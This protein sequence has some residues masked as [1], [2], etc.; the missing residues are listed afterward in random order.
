[1]KPEN[2]KLTL[3]LM[4]SL[5]LGL[6]FTVSPVGA[7]THPLSQITPIDTDLD[8]DG[9][10]ITNVYAIS[11]FFDDPCPDGEVLMHITDT[12]N[13][14]C[15]DPTEDIRDEFVGVAGDTMTGDLIMD[16]ATVTGLVSPVDDTDAVRLTDLEDVEN[17][18]LQ[19][20][21]DVLSIGEDAGGLNM[22]NIGQVGIGTAEPGYE[23]DVVGDVGFSGTLQE[24][25]VPWTRLTDHVDV[26]GGTGITGGGALSSS[27]ELAFDTAWGDDRYYEQSVADGEFVGVAGDTMTGDL[28]MEGAT[29]TGLVSPVDDTDAVRLTDLEDVENDILQD[30]EDVLS[31]GNF[32]GGMGIDMNGGT[33]YDIGD[34]TGA[35]IVDSDQIESNAVSLSELDTTDVDDRYVNQWERWESDLE[36]DGDIQINDGGATG[37]NVVSGRKELYAGDETNVSSGATKELTLVFNE[38]YGH[39]PNHVNVL[40]RVDGEITVTI[41]E[42]SKTMIESGEI[43]TETWDTSEWEDGTY[44]VTATVDSGW[45][46]II[47]FY[48]VM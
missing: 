11:N 9:R 46:D 30:L 29:V 18:T 2:R 17:D 37:T 34:L 16:G 24:G 6:I 19:D 41:N 48:Y 4:T 40:A 20:L 44:D 25:S 21:E 26:T 45:N 8:M 43:I 47:E 32:T 27:R 7:Q 38:N 5:V 36:V 15:V 1:M 28:I 31:I 22:T 10:N 12:G 35:D 33:I 13:F 14:E 3:A 42:E 23:L 39:S